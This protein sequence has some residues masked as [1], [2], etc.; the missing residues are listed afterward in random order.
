MTNERLLQIVRLFL[1][2]AL[3]VTFL[4]SVADRFGWLGPYGT[5]NVSWGD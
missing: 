1:R 5:R 4:V 2:L 3:A